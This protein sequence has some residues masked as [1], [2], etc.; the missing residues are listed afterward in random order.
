MEKAQPIVQTYPQCVS[1]KLPFRRKFGIST[2]EVRFNCFNV[3]ITQLVLPPKIHCS[4]RIR[5]FIGLQWRESFWYR[6]VQYWQNPLAC[7]WKGFR[8]NSRG[9]HI[10]ISQFVNCKSYC[11]PQLIAPLTVP[12]NSLNVQVNF[13]RLKQTKISKLFLP[14]FANKT[15]L[16]SQSVAATHICIT[17]SRPFIQQKHRN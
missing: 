2:I 14:S 16:K 5:E 11:V 4:C 12:N 10:I 3:H 1:G 17:A 15:F 6:F 13:V 8:V 9:R 7:K